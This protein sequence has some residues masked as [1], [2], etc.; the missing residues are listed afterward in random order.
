MWTQGYQES[1]AVPLTHAKIEAVGKQLLP[2]AVNE[3]VGIMDR[4]AAMRDITLMLFLWDSSLMD[5]EGGNLGLR[6]LYDCESGLPLF[7]TNHSPLES[8]YVPPPLKLRIR[9]VGVPRLTSSLGLGR[10]L[11]TEEELTTQTRHRDQTWWDCF[12]AS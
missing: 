5:H 10:Y 6:D 11:S 4:L 7:L 1:L 3:S 8:D 12:G 2:L 9:L